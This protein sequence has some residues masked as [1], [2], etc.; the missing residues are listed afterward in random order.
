[1]SSMLNL[2]GRPT[3]VFDVNN[4]EHR[5]MAHEFLKTRSWGS[6]PVR[7]CL[8]IGEDN[9]YT[10]V[11]RLMTEYYAQKEFGP[12]PKHESEILREQIVAKA[13]QIVWRKLDIKG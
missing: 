4:K 12:I 3:V 6:C 10:M 8:P 11:M 9:V 2:Y 7:F 5:R 1:M 13:P